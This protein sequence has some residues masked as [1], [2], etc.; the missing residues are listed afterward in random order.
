MAR[1][2]RI[3]GA[4]YLVALLA[5]AAAALINLALLPWTRTSLPLYLVA[6][7]IAARA[8]GLGPSLLAAVASLVIQDVIR[9]VSTITL[10]ERIVRA[11]VFLSTAAFVSSLVA[12]RRRAEESER[13]RRVWYEGMLTSVGDGVLAADPAG[14]VS[15]LNAAA[16][17]LTGWP[18]AE[19]IG[20]PI[21]EVIP[22]E[23]PSGE[24]PATASLRLDAKVPAGRAASLVDREGRRRPIEGHAAPVRTPDGEPAGVVVVLRDASGR[25]RAEEASSELAAIVASSNDAIIC[26]GGDDRITSWNPGA[27]RL[28]GYTAAEAIGRPISMLLPPDR[29]DEM[30]RMLTRIEGGAAV[31]HDETERIDKDGRRLDISVS[32]SPLRDGDGRVVGM[33]TIAR[34]VTGR[35]QSERRLAAQYAVGRVLTESA[36]V[37]QAM[38]RLLESLGTT[39]RWDAA[40]CWRIDREAGILRCAADWH[41]GT[42]AFGRVVE[43]C[44]GLT[45]A[46]GDPLPGQVWSEREPIWVEDMAADARFVRASSAGGLIRAVAAFPIVQGDDVLGVVELLGGEARPADDDLLGLFRL[47][48]AQIGLFVERT[49]AEDE[50]RLAEARF[51]RL[52]DSGIL[53]IMIADLDGHLILDANDAFLAMVGATRDDLAARRLDWYEITPPEYREADAHAVAQVMGAGVCDPYVKEYV[54]ADGRRVSVLLGAARMD[55]ESSRCIVFLIDVTERRRTED[56]LRHR[57]EQ[58][59]LALA[60]ARMGTWDWNLD[61]GWLEWSDDLEDIFGLPRGGFGG[62]FEAFAEMVHPDDRAMLGAAM[63][64]AL[65]GDDEYEVEFRVVSPS[66]EILW[67]N[68]R[69]RVFRDASGQPIRLVGVALDITGRKRAEQELQAAKEAADA[70]NLAKDEFLAVL[71]H[72]LR[73]PLTPVLASVSAMLDDPATPE[74]YR[75]ILQMVR[76]N[77]DLEARLI[78]DLLDVTR[79]SRGKL[80]LETRAVDAHELLYQ[81]L[82]ICVTD[83]RDKGL[84]LQV[85]LDAEAHH[86]EADPAR[87]QQVYWNLI[88]NAVKFTPTDGVLTLRS[89]DAGDGRLVVEVADTGMGIDAGAMPNIFNAFEQGDASITRRFGGL[90]LGLAISRSVVEL[91]GGTL[92]ASSAGR[93][94]GST[95]RI[96]MASVA[97]PAESAPDG[98]CRDGR[99]VDPLREHGPLRILLVEDSEDSLLV[100]ARLLRLRGHEVVAADSVGSAAEVS[101]TAA[102]AFD[103][104]ISDLGLPDGTGLDVIRLVREHSDCP[105]I[106]LSGFGMESDIRRTREAG[107]AA[108]LVKPVELSQLEATI[109]QVVAA[110]PEARETPAR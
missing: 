59:R 84:H 102:G 15:F 33:A 42:P 2:A 25:R 28:F 26:R 62:T 17:A 36:T 22:I 91:L 75:S 70:A 52:A 11:I 3:A 29:T 5:V 89:R 49:R 67:I 24:H 60:V 81:A 101:A 103:L 9:S 7:M 64:R 19:A 23:V 8:G 98:E 92:T 46:R 16:E 43:G 66:A 77:V 105:A 38:P 74:D 34:D 109:R 58:L 90:G 108:H 68:A 12:A 93:D 106:A 57:E 86:V 78:D 37:A 65:G 69:G 61:N 83:L 13:G 53:G 56:A 45:F 107:F 55:A 54:R 40:L 110:S 44:R 96:E 41:R 88:K 51:R 48:G 71:S 18:A 82:E 87:L 72:E 6:V 30:P 76:R 100:L 94:R 80:A 85:A 73:T 27:E 4:E 21:S 47:V 31:S 39:L 14:R 32:V 79:I 99:P 95:F 35:R 20:R 104:L 10:T 1:W 97:P 63:D 50:L